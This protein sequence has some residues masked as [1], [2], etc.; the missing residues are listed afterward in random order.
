MQYLRQHPLEQVE[1]FFRTG[2]YHID[3]GDKPVFLLK[4]FYPEK[5]GRLI[6]AGQGMDMTTLN[7]VDWRGDMIYA[8]NVSKVTIRDIH[9]TRDTPGATQ[10]VVTKVSKGQVV[11]RIPEGFPTPDEVHDG[12]EME[13]K[14]RY[15]R[16]Y[17]N[18][19]SP[20][21]VLPDNYQV[22]WISTFQYKPNTRLWAF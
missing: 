3:G 12:H 7:F 10:G 22:A 11:L 21:V 2:H 8:T 20:Q 19:S 6:I 5:N 18:I 9:L 15:L 13:S 4:Q 17:T 16:K 1:L 14:R